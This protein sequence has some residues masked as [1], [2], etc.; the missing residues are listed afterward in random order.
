[1]KI[2][3]ETNEIVYNGKLAKVVFTSF[4]YLY[5]AE[6]RGELVCIEVNAREHVASIGGPHD[7]PEVH[8]ASIAVI[9][10]INREGE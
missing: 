3:H 1:M 8:D 2:L 9:D 5:L 10:H 4:K 7:L 6:Y